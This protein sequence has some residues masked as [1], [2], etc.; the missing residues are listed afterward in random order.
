MTKEPFYLTEV[1]EDGFSLFSLGESLEVEDP[2]PEFFHSSFDLPTNKK[3][4][5][6]IAK[7]SADRHYYSLR[8]EGLE[9]ETFDETDLDADNLPIAVSSGTV[10]EGPLRF[11]APMRIEGKV[12]GAIKST[13]LVVVG[14]LAEVSASIHADSVIVCG[15]LKGSVKAATRVVVRAGGCL[16]G[17]VHSPELIV[18]SG[19][20]YEGQSYF[21]PKK[22]L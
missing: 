3:E 15:Y 17:K 5:L 12:S 21:S 13:A 10:L 11:T 9:L 8:N 7:A 20:A 16:T 19:G 4:T 14:E 2:I 1:V 22:V 6:H 18:E